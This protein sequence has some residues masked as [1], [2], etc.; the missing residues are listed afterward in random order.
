[1]T[2]RLSFCTSL[3]K[4]VSMSVARSAPRSCRSSPAARSR[5]GGGRVTGG[6][7][8]H[9]DQRRGGELERALDDLAGVDRRMIDGPALLPL[10]LDQYV[11]A[12][13]EEDVE[14]LDCAVSD[15]CGA[16]IDQLVPRVDHRALVQF[17]PHQPQRRLARRL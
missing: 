1:M 8:V 10:V 11:F 12:V 2:G 17:R 7:V 4:A 6:V 3:P 5:P 13:E 16:I 15:L 9:Q 14:L